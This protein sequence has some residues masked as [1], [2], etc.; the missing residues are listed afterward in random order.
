MSGHRRG[1]GKPRRADSR[2]ADH[3]RR[4]MEAPTGRAQVAAAF[5][6]CRSAAVRHPDPDGSLHEVAIW[7]NERAKALEAAA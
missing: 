5:D 4:V 2:I 1:T 3:E 6:R 7:L